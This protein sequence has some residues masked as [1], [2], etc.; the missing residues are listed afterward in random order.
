MK[1]SAINKIV[2]KLEILMISVQY[3]KIQ[4]LILKNKIKNNLSLKIS[5]KQMILDLMDLMKTMKMILKLEK[6]L[7]I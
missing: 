3:K 4:T 5:R 2:L 7:Q 6:A 1:L